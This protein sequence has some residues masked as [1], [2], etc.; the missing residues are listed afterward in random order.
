MTG[1]AVIATTGQ[2]AKVLQ[3]FAQTMLSDFQIQ[4]ILDHLVTR[5]VEVMPVSGAGV[6]VISP[7]EH[8]R[9][10]A[11]SDEAALRYENLQDVL[12]DGPCVAA[13]DSDAA[14]VVP[15]LR[16][17]T[18]FR[19][20]AARAVAEGLRAV[21]TFP[22]RHGDERL[23]ALDLYQTKPGPL[24]PDDMAVAQTLADVASAYL[25]NARARF[26][27]Q[28]SLQ[29]TLDQTLHDGL[30]G[31]PNRALLI[32]RLEHS[33]LRAG[34]TGRST[35][36][37]FVDLD[38]FKAV[39]DRL[40]HAAGD[41]LLI[42]VSARLGQ[43]LRDG[44]T[45]ARLSG[46][47]FVVICED[48]HDDPGA[49]VIASRLGKAF[50]SPFELAA[51]QAEI[52]A[53]IGVAFADAGVASAEALLH[54]ADVAMYRA[55]REGGARVRVY[56]RAY[57]GQLEEAADLERDLRHALDGGELQTLYQPIV[58]TREGSITGVEA[59]LRWKHPTRGHIP[60][61]TVIA[62]AE[63]NGQIDDIG[64]WV[65]SQAARQ[66]RRWSESGTRL[67]MSV[68][69]SA[70]QLTSPGFADTV[71][72]VLSRTGADPALLT[73]EVTETVL[74]ADHQRALSVLTALKELGIGLALDDFGT[75]YCSLTYL[76]RFPIDVVKIDR[77]FV[78]DIGAD[79]VSDVIVDAVVRLADRLGM[80]VVAEGIETP[81]QLRAVADLGCHS[82]Q[83]F[84][85]ARPLPGTD[86]DTLLRRHPG[87][88]PRLPA[89]R[90]D[91][92]G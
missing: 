47:E 52:T 48:L 2:L 1:G 83:G 38:G 43:S 77:A 75:G 3:D 90:I 82:C 28:Q 63:R 53:S 79:P 67:T 23:G 11:A 12:G 66:A 8:P 32:D 74:L 69:V 61:A 68:N 46:D 18:R 81:R 64:H 58:T 92:P 59:L 22:L 51:G 20:F 88:P 39:N 55:K 14:I 6:T 50:G 84:Y 15:D 65:L 16:E 9:Y 33:F 44:D 54:R 41:E 35:A 31:L 56:D 86:I 71:A 34:R 49:L 27:L 73:L 13:F 62:L 40:G 17:E 45:L 37:L 26:R 19:V 87:S 29:Q 72:D 57:H 80:R 60:A 76:L 10:V 85:F 42:Q 70:H 5:I 4:A 91:Q 7:G 25:I 89:D 78:A 21:F 36:A 24:D 30:T